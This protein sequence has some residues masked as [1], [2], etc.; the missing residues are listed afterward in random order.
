MIL[1]LD[2]ETNGREGEEREVIELAWRE[3]LP[4][5]WSLG[6]EAYLSRFCPK[7][8]STVGALSIHHILNEELIG[9]PPSSEARLP[10]ETSF[11]IGHGVDYDWE[12]L[13]RPKVKRICTLAI[14]RHL[15][16]KLDS[17]RLG[18]MMYALFEDHEAIRRQLRSAHQAADDMNFC[19]LILQQMLLD[20]ELS[21]PSAQ[22]LWKFSEDCRVPSLMPF[23][24]HKGLEISKLPRDYQSW[25]LRQPDFDPYILE[26]IRRVGK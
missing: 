15:Y 12:S 7:K 2:T 19:L 25:C 18:A 24:K 3:I 4:A 22:A 5:T 8:P 14:A 11:I 10:E 1:V 20:K 13:G 9:K 16:P 26:A 21:F 17:H 6:G 23:G